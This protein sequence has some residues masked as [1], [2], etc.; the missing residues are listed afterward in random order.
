MST[1]VAQGEFSGDQAGNVHVSMYHIFVKN[2]DLKRK[3]SQHFLLYHCQLKGW[4]AAA[5]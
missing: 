2:I 3:L 1:E 5:N 4:T